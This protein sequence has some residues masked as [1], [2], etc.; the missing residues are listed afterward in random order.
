LFFVNPNAARSVDLRRVHRIRQLHSTQTDAV[1]DLLG[2]M[3]ACAV[4]DG[5]L[6]ELAADVEARVPRPLS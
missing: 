2:R 6:K 3:G 1:G 4:F 5:S